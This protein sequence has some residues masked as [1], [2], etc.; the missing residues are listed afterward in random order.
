[1]LRI[2]VANSKGG[3]GKTTVTSTLAGYYARSGRRTVLVDCDPQGSSLAWCSLR[4]AHLAPVHGVSSN[5]PSHGMSTS[6]MLRIPGNTDVLL[7]DTPAGLRAHEFEQFGR[8]ADVLL[9]PVVP[10]PIDL[11]ATLGFIDI[12]RRMPEVRQGKL[13]VG[14]IINRLRERTNSAKQLD[15]TLQRLTQT[16]LARVRDSQT[17][18]GLSDCGQSLFD[19]NSSQ[20]RSHREDWLPLL[21][22]LDQRAAEIGNRGSVTRLVPQAQR[23]GGSS[24]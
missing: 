24:T 22:W 9:I 8:H 4:A 11:R 19:Q 5:D 21:E 23:L 20:T 7:I 2:L 17:Y 10:S 6:W 15:I 16:A 1:M 18:V 14:L 13:R 3:C 12:V